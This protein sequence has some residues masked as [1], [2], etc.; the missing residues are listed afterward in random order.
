MGGG[1]ELQKADLAT[2]ATLYR[3]GKSNK[4]IS[5]ESGVSSLSAQRWT[6]HFHE[7]GSTEIPTTKKRSGRPRSVPPHTLRLVQ[8]EIE[9]NPCITLKELKK[10]NPKLLGKGSDRTAREYLHRD[11]EYKRCVARKKPLLNEKQCSNR[12]EFCK[13]YSE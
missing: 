2:I 11:L 10:K 7:A 9:K 13:K 5:E 8:C 3:C 1:K 4:E 12:L 6:K